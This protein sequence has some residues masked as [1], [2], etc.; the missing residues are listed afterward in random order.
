[1]RWRARRSWWGGVDTA[2]ALYT[3]LIANDDD[4]LMAPYYLQLTR[5]VGERPSRR[6]PRSAATPSW[7]SRSSAS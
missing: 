3:I 7:A 4:P 2:P 5:E 6:A 1:M